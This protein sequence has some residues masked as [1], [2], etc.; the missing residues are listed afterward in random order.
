MISLTRC[1]VERDLFRRTVLVL[2]VMALTAFP[3]LAPAQEDPCSKTGIYIL[4]QTQR[5]SWFTRNEGSCTFWAHHYLLTIKP[6]DAFIIYKDIDCKTEFFSGNPTY[7]GYKSLDA[8]QDCRV[9]ILFNGTLS[10]L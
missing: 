8:N 3:L 2:M 9:R 1:I 5:D 6:G 10:D 4:N 7:D